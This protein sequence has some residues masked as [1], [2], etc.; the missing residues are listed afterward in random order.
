[1]VRNW[2]RVPGIPK[3][4]WRDGFRD[5]T[6]YSVNH[7][8]RIRVFPFLADGTLDPDAVG[9]ISGILRDKNTD[10]IREVHPRLIKLLYKLA[11]KFDARQVNVISGYRAPKGE[12]G[13]GHHADASAVDITFPGVKLAALAKAARRLGHVGVGYYPTSGFIHLDVRSGR[14]YFWADRSGPGKPS[15]LFAVMKDAAGKLDARWSPGDDEP[16]PARN[17]AG[18]LLGVTIPPPGQEEAA[19]D[20]GAVPVAPRAGS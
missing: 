8:E 12:E 7:G 6:I 11:V 20:G 1:M 14:S 16:E 2:Q 3:P 17:K 18:E 13:G 10:S 15:C 19:A 5:L 4:R 9:A